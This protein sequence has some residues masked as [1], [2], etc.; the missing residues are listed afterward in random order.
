MCAAEVLGQP[1][2]SKTP[3]TTVAGLALHLSH[4][5]RG[6][7]GGQASQPTG[8]CPG[9]ATGHSSGL[10]TARPVR[11]SPGTPGSRPCKAQGWASPRP[12]TACPAVVR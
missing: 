2:D 12:W 7:S 3:C 9:L 5:H 11:P 4:Q 8:G 10:P 6:I 1:E